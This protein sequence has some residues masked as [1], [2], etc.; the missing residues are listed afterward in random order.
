MS[1]LS[2][3]CKGNKDRLKLLFRASKDGFSNDIF[4]ERCDNQGPLLFLAQTSKDII[5]GG[6]SSLNWKN[7][8]NW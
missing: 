1:V 7:V 2:T 3:S 8:G 6:Y 5:I 4:H